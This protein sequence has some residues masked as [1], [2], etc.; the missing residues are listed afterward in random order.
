MLPYK[1]FIVI[2]FTDVTVFVNEHIYICILTQV[3]VNEQV[4]TQHTGKLHF[5]ETKHVILL[6]LHVW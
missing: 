2:F 3:F 1:N 6:I 5:Q 4:S